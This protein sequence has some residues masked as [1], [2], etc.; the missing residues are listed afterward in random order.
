MLAFGST[1]NGELGLGGIDE[2]Q[3]SSPRHLH[4]PTGSAIVQV[5]CGYDHTLFC[6]ETGSVLSC[7]SNERGQLAQQITCRKP[8]LVE[9]LDSYSVRCVCAGDKFSL[10]LT[11]WGGVLSWGDNSYGQ[12]GNGDMSVSMTDRP[13]QIRALSSKQIV[14]VAAGRVHCLALANDGEVFTWGGSLACQFDGTKHGHVPLPQLI[15]YLLSVP[16]SRIACGGYH[17]LCLSKTGVL[18]AWG[19]NTFGQLGVGNCDY[20][21]RPVAVSALTSRRVKHLVCGENHSAVLT[22]DG[23]V[24]TFGADTYGQLGHGGATQQEVPRQVFELM[25]S[26]TRQLVCGRFHTLVMS[27]RGQ[28]KSFGLGG[29]GQLGCGNLQPSKLP[30]VVRIPLEKECGTLRIVAGGNHNFVFKLSDVPAESTWM[31]DDRLSSSQSQI[32]ELTV[33]GARAIHQYATSSE[34]STNDQI[35]DFAERVLS[36]VACMNGSFLLYPVSTEDDLTPSVDG[37]STGDDMSQKLGSCGCQLNPNLDVTACGISLHTLFQITSGTVHDLVQS[38]LY[39]ILPASLPQRPPHTH[40]LRVYMVLLLLPNFSAICVQYGELLLSLA[41]LHWKTVAHWLRWLPVERMILVVNAY[42]QAV[43]HYLK[44]GCDYTQTSNGSWR[45]GGELQVCLRTLLRLHSALLGHKLCGVPCGSARV[46]DEAFYISE[47]TELISVPTDYLAWQCSSE[48]EASSYFCYYPFVF[49]AAAKTKLLHTDAVFQMQ[50]A[51]QSAASQQLTNLLLFSHSSASDV[52]QYL[53]LTVSRDN[54]VHDTIDQLV[55]LSSVDLKKPLRVRFSGEEAEDAGGVRKEFFMILMRELL[56]PKYGMFVEHSDTLAI[57]FSQDSF[58]ELVMYF[59]FGILCGLAIYNSTIVNLPFPLVLYRKILGQ[60]VS[61]SDLK[62]LSPTLHSSLRQLLEYE[63]DDVEE[64]F[65]LTFSVSRSVFGEVR[66]DALIVNGE[67][68]SVTANNREEYVHLY[69]DYLLNKS[70][71][72]PFS[73]F[74][75]G[76][77]RVCGSKV[78]QLFTPPELMTLVRGDENYDWLEFERNAGYREGYTKESPPVVLFWKVFHTLSEQQKKQFLLYLT[79][80]DRVPILGMKSIKMFIQPSGGG[81]NYLPVAHTCFNLLDL[82]RY[83]TA[84]KLRFKLLQAI[85]C[86]EGFGL[87]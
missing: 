10:A 25:G 52:S 31:V 59:L 3:I 13:K 26:V 71:E 14:Q 39:H 55:Q 20:Q 34:P 37:P 70:I 69:V 35:I 43:L 64:V 83:N 23:A 60:S 76:F 66:S 32:L 86:T 80:S 67:H 11:Q 79:G 77:H 29:S 7:G 78:L 5:S 16:L 72:K 6:T 45:I 62:D 81:D 47:L 75:S 58:E 48:D 40:A 24:F 57:W 61:L 17:S 9:A 18:F 73:A 87:A 85:Q 30:Q 38:R 53:V 15:R 22:E 1:V 68:I 50:S 19:E 2:E 4:I 65:C 54:L 74:C 12:L 84:E 82:P 44:K 36:S 56:D 21:N 33:N 51:M 28:V 63:G 49:D 46:A 42:K 8:S 41:D 27:S